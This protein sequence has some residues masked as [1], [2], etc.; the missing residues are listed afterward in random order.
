VLAAIAESDYDGCLSLEFEG[1]EDCRQ[2]A[3]RGL[4]N[5]KTL[6]QTATVPA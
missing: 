3:E 5:L 2:G 1:M 4:A 6:W